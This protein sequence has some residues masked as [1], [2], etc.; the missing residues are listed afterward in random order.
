M[1]ARL[2]YA[3]EAPTLFAIYCDFIHPELPG[4][5]WKPDFA[6]VSQF[7]QG[8]ASEEFTLT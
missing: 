1:V 3:N 2:L 8:L 6:E 7:C 4:A 5:Q